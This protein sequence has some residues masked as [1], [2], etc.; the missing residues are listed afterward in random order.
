MI[1][2]FT[3]SCVL[4]T[5]ATACQN[6][7]SRPK[8]VLPRRE[9]VRVL[10]E[11]YLAEAKI[12]RMGIAGDS[13]D[14][15]FKIYREK[16]FDHTQVSDSVFRRSFDYYRERPQDMELIYTALVDSLNLREQRSSFAY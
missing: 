11:I 2:F 10:M 9:M 8:D 7:S 3:I 13:S 5:L 12:S 14:R 16:V 1:R 4:L 6:S 15:V